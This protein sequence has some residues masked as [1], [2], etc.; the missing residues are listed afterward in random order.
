MRHVLILAGL[1]FS[2]LSINAQVTNSGNM[3]L[4]SGARIAFFGD[5][6]NNG[7]LVDSGLV[8]TMAGVNP[9]TVGGST[10][11]TFNNLTINNTH[12]T[13]VTLN[14]N[15]NVRGAL[16]LTDGYVNTAPAAILTLTNTAT[17]TG[18]S[19]A[20]F[21]SGPMKKTGN[22][23]FV[24]PVGKN[25]VHAP[26]AISAPAL[27]TD[28]FM[29]EYFKVSPNPLYSVASK[30][31]TLDH[32]ST[33]EYWMINQTAGSSVVT[34]N[35][36]W[37]TRSCGINFIPDLRI[38][39]WDGT[40]WKNQGNGGTTGTISA[41]TVVSFSALT[42]FGPFT[43]GSISGSNPLPIELTAFEGDCS[44]SDVVLTWTTA[45]EINNDY[46]VLERS[47][48]G[49]HWQVLTAVNGAGNSSAKIHYAYTDP[50]PLQEK[51]LYY[52]ILQT[53]YDGTSKSVG[54]VSLANCKGVL[55]NT[56][57]VYPNP[58]NGKFYTQFSGDS[59]D[60]QSL[61]VFN[62]YG[63]SIAFESDKSVLVDLTG[64]AAGIYLLVLNLGD[65]IITQ[66]LI[67]E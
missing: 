30:E 11:T 66:K 27:I 26:F 15:L 50:N 5:V 36:S 48:D 32:V 35:L 34:V 44:G 61:Q 38:A 37:D 28:Q 24:F 10:T 42:N 1:F 57:E 51:T 65:E 46:F 33:C 23:A 7:T 25:L 31:V 14:Q 49:E 43:L 8:V 60:I 53:D 9:Q 13:G 58:S 22:T 41:G 19:N 18:A 2:A 39:R 21:V 47:R 12:V 56:L 45:S 67:V 6:T 62:L 17:T 59:D 40:Q 16:T 64:Q 20:S 3:K 54:T 55:E 63:E 4:F 29:G 52:R